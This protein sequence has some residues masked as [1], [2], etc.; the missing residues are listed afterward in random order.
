M[1]RCGPDI[2]LTVDR[3]T[4]GRIEFTV[5]GCDDIS[6]DPIASFCLDWYAGKLQLVVDD[7]D[8]VDVKQT[9]QLWETPADLIADVM[10]VEKCGFERVQLDSEYVDWER[11]TDLSS[12]T[13]FMERMTY[14]VGQDGWWASLEVCSEDS[15]LEKD[16]GSS[17]TS[18]TPHGPLRWL[19]TMKKFHLDQQ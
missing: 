7:E 15:T 9:A 17:N 19:A 14:S 4:D 6:A 5:R 13:S 12:E 3:G 1:Y 18:E 8:R 11:H 16:Y 2:F 10:F